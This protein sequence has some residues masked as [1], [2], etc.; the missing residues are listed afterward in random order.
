[1]RTYK[2]TL[3]VDY[4]IKASSLREA[5]I[6]VK[7]NSEHPLVGGSE[8]GYCDAVRVIGGGIKK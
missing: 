7:E 5:Q 3:E 6:L 8:V 1:M 2:I 4:V